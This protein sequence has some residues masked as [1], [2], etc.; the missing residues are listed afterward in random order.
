MAPCDR[1]P[2]WAVWG[3]SAPSR[4]SDKAWIRRLDTAPQTGELVAMD[5]R[6]RLFPRRVRRLMV[7]RDQIC[8]TPRCDAP[9]RHADHV[10]AVARGGSTSVAN[11]QGLCEACNYAKE[12]PGWRADVVA[13][14]PHLIEITTPTTP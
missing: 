3:C 14:L 4:S 10:R 6:K 5:S 7:L 2:H 12:S 13:T 8:R 1:A 11:G 9:I